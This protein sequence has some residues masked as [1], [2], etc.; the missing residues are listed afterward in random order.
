VGRRGHAFDALVI[1]EV[2]R[3]SGRGSDGRVHRFLQHLKQDAGNELD[4]AAVRQFGVSGKYGGNRP[5]AGQRHIQDKI[6]SC[7]TC[8]LQQFRMQ[9]IV[10]DGALHC[11]RIP[12]EFRTVQHLDGFLRGQT[13]SN[14]FPA[15]GEAEHEMRLDETERD[16]EIGRR[17]P[18][19]DMHRRT[20]F[21]GA[22]VAMGREIPGVVIH[23]PES[24]RDF[25]SAYLANLGF[26]GGAVQSGGNQDGDIF[27]RDS[28]AFQPAEYRGQGQAV[29]RR[30][31]NI[32]NG[33]G[34]AVFAASKLSQWRRADR[35]IE[36]RFQSTFPIGDRRRRASLQNAVLE[37]LRQTDGNP[38][39]PES[40]LNLH[41][42][43]RTT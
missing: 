5:V 40:E 37:S 7:Q 15:A 26:G 1:R 28:G 19:V 32:A 43:H 17:K 39:L 30:A 13:R 24:G 9:R 34:G 42:R 16:V 8:N 2:E 23:H 41:Q 18:L 36:R 3:V 10:L 12:H 31:G 22:Q 33:D 4:A 29:W 14:Q 20:R 38:C 11:A 6:V 27:A 35:A 25:L 21:G